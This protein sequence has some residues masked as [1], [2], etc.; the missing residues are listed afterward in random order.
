VF[1]TVSARLRNRRDGS[2]ARSRS[3]AGAV[4]G[5]AQLPRLLTSLRIDGPAGG[6]DLDG[7]AVSPRGRA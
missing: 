4:P 6:D 7:V 5:H 2:G 1:L 3:G